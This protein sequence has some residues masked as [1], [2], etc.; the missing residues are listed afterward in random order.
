MSTDSTTDGLA[1]FGTREQP[2]HDEQ[3]SHQTDLRSIGVRRHGQLELDEFSSVN[4]TRA[5]ATPE[6]LEGGR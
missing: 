3:H 4:D 6:S 5:W 2:V 1:R